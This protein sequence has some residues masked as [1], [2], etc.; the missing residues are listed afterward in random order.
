MAQ[1]WRPRSALERKARIRK[2]LDKVERKSREWLE[3]CFTAAER[4]F[5]AQWRRREGRFYGP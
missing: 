3:Y 1:S 5:E 4:E 2:I